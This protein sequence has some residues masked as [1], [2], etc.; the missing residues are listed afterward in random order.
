MPKKYI[1]KIEDE[2]LVRKSALHGETAVWCACGFN[3]LVFD[4]N[5]LDKL[6]PYTEPKC[7]GYTAE[8]AWEAVRAIINMTWE[9]RH[10]VFGD[11]DHTLIDL[12]EHFTASEAIKRINAYGGESLKH[13]IQSLMDSYGYTKNEFYYALNAMKDTDDLPFE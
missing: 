6:T 8:Q 12:F 9:Q 1:I 7:G 3:S 2:P 10:E 4:K 13:H 11:D 5:G